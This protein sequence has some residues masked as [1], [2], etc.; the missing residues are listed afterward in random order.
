MWQLATVLDI[1]DIEHF[2]HFRKFFQ[3]VLAP[4]GIAK[5]EDPR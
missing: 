1:V 2:H 4:E 3:T 5:H